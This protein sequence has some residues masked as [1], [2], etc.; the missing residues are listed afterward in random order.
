[1]VRTILFC[2]ANMFLLS[3]L[4]GQTLPIDPKATEETKNLY[5]NLQR[6]AKQ[7]IM[8]GHQD[9][10]AY[11]IG[12]KYEPGRSDVKEVAGQYPAVVG[13]D[14]GYLELK[15]PMNLDSVPFDKMREYAQQVYA[16]GGLN[17]FSW[18]LNNPVDP[19][20]T[21]WDH[22]D[23]TIQQLFADKKAMRR[24]KRWLRRV[25][26]FM[27]SLEGQE[28]EAIPVIFRP[29]HEHNGSWFWWG[30]GHATPEEYKKL[31]RFTVEYLRDKKRVH[32]L[33][34]AYSPDKF[35][36]KEEFLERYPGDEYVDV[37]GFDIYHRPNPADSVDTF[38]KDARR[39][40]DMLKEIGEERN[41]VYA[42]TEGGLE[43]IPQ[44]DWWTETLLPVIEDSGLSYVLVWRNGRPDHYYAPYPGQGSA[45]NF[46]AFSRKPNI[47]L[48]D[49]V[50]AE[51]I[52][53]PPPPEA[54]TE[55]TGRN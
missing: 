15:S 1:M 53:A 3:V 5:A 17:T 45:E 42:I 18:H 46:K 43:R 25:A 54:E 19:A 51:N 36:S 52:Y 26:R 13:W 34:Y 16:R 41:K 40:V 20:K 39:M 24:Y 30:Q 11:G 10:L 29:L 9:D 55:A 32:N 4:S 21:S 23:S 28:G 44:P 37:I 22:Q 7:G 33:L 12:W 49:E 47:L 50:A 38:V 2:I 35:Y 31:Y 8:F 27:K 48:G 14:L 6:L